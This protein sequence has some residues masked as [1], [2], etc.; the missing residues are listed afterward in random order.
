MQLRTMQFRNEEKWLNITFETVLKHISDF[1]SLETSKQEIPEK[2]IK[3]I[4]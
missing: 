1:S 4:N 2:S 3:N